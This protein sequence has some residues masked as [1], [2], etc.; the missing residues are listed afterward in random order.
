M[1]LS[2]FSISRHNAGQSLG[3]GDNAWCS[4]ILVLSITMLNITVTGVVSCAIL[5]NLSDITYADCLSLAA[6]TSLEASQ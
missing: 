5:H 2:M 4:S 6:T 1:I 3:L